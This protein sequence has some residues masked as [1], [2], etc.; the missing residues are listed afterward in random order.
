MAGKTLY[1]I[2]ELSLSA[3]PESVR[4][5]YERLSAKFAADSLNPDAKLRADAT[6]EAFLTLSNPA[7]RA[8]Y[9]K[10]LATRSQPVIYNLVS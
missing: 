3:S 5:A 7:K 8:Q 6:T 9:D 4:S 1:D 2:L 10:T